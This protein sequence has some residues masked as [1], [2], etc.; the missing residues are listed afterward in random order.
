VS[1]AGEYRL[2]VTDE[3]QTLYND[4]ELVG[5]LVKAGFVVND[6]KTYK[7]L[8]YSVFYVEPK[9]VTKGAAA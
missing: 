7:A 3:F 2:R 5:P 9:S 6:I 4:P 1:L 8:G